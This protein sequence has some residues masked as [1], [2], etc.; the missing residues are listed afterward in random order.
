MNEDERAE[1]D[2]NGYY[3]ILVPDNG[4]LVFKAGLNKA[5]LEKVSNRM[6]I[7]VEVG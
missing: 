1:T 7:D 6:K 5:I 2:A 4:A 3:E